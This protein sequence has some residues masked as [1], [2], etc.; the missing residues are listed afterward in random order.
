[1]PLCAIARIM[2]TMS[3]TIWTILIVASLSVC[4][5]Q[6]VGDMVSAKTAQKLHRAAAVVFWWMV[7]IFVIGGVIGL[8]SFGWQHLG[9]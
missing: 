7:A 1:L 5:W 4:A 6:I 3:S 2:A 9:K 8:L